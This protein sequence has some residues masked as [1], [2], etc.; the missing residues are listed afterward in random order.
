[1]SRREEKRRG[2]RM[3]LTVCTRAIGTLFVVFLGT[4]ANRRRQHHSSDSS[5]QFP[6]LVAYL[7]PLPFPALLPLSP[8]L[9]SQ[10][11]PTNPPP[12]Q[13]PPTPQHAPT[14]PTP[15]PPPSSPPNS[16]TAT[17]PASIIS[18]SQEVQIYSKL[19]HQHTS[20]GSSSHFTYVRTD[21]RSVTW[22]G[23]T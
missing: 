4:C 1:M 14:N 20:P 2:G 18:I 7:T 22:P 12:A 19:P 6:Y 8:H 3:R 16:P 11:P 9:P 5:P 10:P 13:K 17:T 23:S 21:A 15:Q